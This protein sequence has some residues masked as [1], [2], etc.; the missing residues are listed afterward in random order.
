MKK[1]LIMVILL[2][3]PSCVPYR[4][5]TKAEKR[6]LKK[7]A[8]VPATPHPKPSI[9]KKPKRKCYAYE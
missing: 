4:G 2:L 1:L 6:D 7:R 3:I 8:W 9:W 5:I